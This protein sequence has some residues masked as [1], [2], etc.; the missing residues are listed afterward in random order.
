MGRRVISRFIAIQVFKK[1]KQKAHSLYRS[2]VR[3]RIV[4]EL[5]AQGVRQYREWIIPP[6]RI[7]YRISGKSVYVLC[8]LDSRQNI[9]DILFEEAG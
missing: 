2:P 1:I 8:V 4:P 7:V 6:W 5:Q 9:E 3:G